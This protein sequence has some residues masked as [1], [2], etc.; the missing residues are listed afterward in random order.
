MTS[1]TTEAPIAYHNNGSEKELFDSA[2]NS[3]L[4]EQKH[5]VQFRVEEASLETPK[6]IA[7]TT[8]PWSDGY[9]WKSISNTNVT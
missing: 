8:K 4:D 3:N 2:A 9:V 7:P 6:L 5:N 1:V